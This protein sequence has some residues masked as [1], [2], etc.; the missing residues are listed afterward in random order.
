MWSPGYDYDFNMKRNGDLKWYFRIDAQFS[1]QPPIIGLGSS[2]N[3]R[4]V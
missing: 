1:E 4:P 2:P 3:N